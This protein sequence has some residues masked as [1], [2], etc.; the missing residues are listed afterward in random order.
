MM[1]RVQI[2][3]KGCMDERWSEWL[4]GLTITHTG[5]NETILAGLLADQAALYGLLSKLRDLG[6]S[7]VTVKIGEEGSMR[8]DQG[9]A[10]TEGTSSQTDPR[11]R[12]R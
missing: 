1:Q 12:R 10:P 8:E 7:L 2:C 5:E 6:L 4:E 3:V 11:C 9:S